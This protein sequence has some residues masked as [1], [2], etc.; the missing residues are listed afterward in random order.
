MAEEDGD[1]H[2]RKS[3]IIIISKMSRTCCFICSICLPILTG[4]SFTAMERARYGVKHRFFRH[5]DIY[6]PYTNDQSHLWDR[7]LTEHDYIA[8]LYEQYGLHEH[9][10]YKIVNCTY[11]TILRGN[12][13]CF[14]DLYQIFANPN[15]QYIIFEDGALH[16]FAH[17]LNC[18]LLDLRR[19]IV[20][21]HTNFIEI[22]PHTLQPIA[23]RVASWCFNRPSVHNI[24]YSESIGRSVPECHYVS[25]CIHGIRNQFFVEAL[26]SGNS[27]YFMGKI[28]DAH[29]NL[30]AILH[31]T[32]HVANLH[33]YG[34]GV[35]EPMLGE[36]HHCIY[37]GMSTSPVQDL[38]A[39]KIYISYSWKEGICSTTMEALAMNKYAL[40]L[41]CECNRPFRGMTNAY[42]FKTDAD[43][44]GTL[45]MLMRQPPRIE[46]KKYRLR[47]DHANATF[48]RH[49]MRIRR[50]SREPVSHTIA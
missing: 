5:V 40:L 2:R 10:T 47:W 25:L 38:S 48:F 32:Q 26:P 3:C 14:V 16:F 20:I 37:H 36:Y 31:A 6:F 35:D 39:H 13:A 44:V 30:R 1:T 28:D 50:Q 4:P 9:V 19:T 17:P 23:V 15:Y 34:T 27:V 42:F 45:R 41:D 49:L 12:S 33:V 24:V 46:R 43:L 7:H 18:M 11:S 22:I 21:H 8:Y 29:K